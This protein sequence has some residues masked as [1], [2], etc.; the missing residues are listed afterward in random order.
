MEGGQGEGRR[1]EGGPGV[2]SGGWWS[3]PHWV[4]SGEGGSPAH[5]EREVQQCLR[6]WWRLSPFRGSHWPQWRQVACLLCLKLGPPPK[7]RV[8]FKHKHD[9]L[10][11]HPAFKRQPMHSRRGNRQ[12]LEEVYSSY[13]SHGGIF[14]DRYECTS[15]CVALL[16]EW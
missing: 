11:Y 13:L 15:F 10:T 7:R 12:P 16:G 3:F 2:S 1:G 5:Q 6:R 14:V 9:T 4:W 8:Q